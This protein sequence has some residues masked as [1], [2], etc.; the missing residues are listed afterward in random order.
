MQQEERKKQ[1]AVF[2]QAE[3]LFSSDKY[4]MLRRQ[5][6]EEMNTVAD[7]VFL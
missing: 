4:D 6:Y 3:T 2:A 7:E 1:E 5:F